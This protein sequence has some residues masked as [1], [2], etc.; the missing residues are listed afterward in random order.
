[1]EGPVL[2]LSKAVTGDQIQK[3]RWCRSQ[4]V[5]RR[6]KCCVALDPVR[7]LLICDGSGAQFLVVE[8]GS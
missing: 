3:V 2:D 8:L 7:V 5:C 1:M 4:E 6:T